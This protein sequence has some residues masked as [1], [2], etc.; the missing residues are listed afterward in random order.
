MQCIFFQ[1]KLTVQSRKG[2]QGNPAAEAAELKST[3][4]ISTSFV[5]EIR[6]IVFP[7]LL[8]GLEY[9]GPYLIIED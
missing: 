7:P 2:R 8:K 3:A 1:S 6:F 4:A 9:R 5:V